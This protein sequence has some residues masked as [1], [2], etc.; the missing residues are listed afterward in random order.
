MENAEERLEYL[1]ATTSENLLLHGDLH[2]DNILRQGEEKWA[3][4]DPKGIIGDIHFDTIQY[5]L[6]YEDRGG[7]CEQVLRNRIA[8]MADRLGLDP[9][10][11]AMWGVARGVLR[12]AGRL[13]TEERIGTEASKSRNALPNVWIEVY[14][15]R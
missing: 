7:D 13:K 2:H 14:Q 12:R 8:N 10:R 4:I 3:V 1:I 5:L 11:I 9:R 6:N 15:K